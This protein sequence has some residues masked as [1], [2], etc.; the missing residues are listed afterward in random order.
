MITK[1]DALNRPIETGLWTNAIIATTHRTNATNLPEG[2]FE[3]P[4]T[5]GTYEI[6]TKTHYN[7]YIGLSSPLT[8]TLST[9]YINSTNFIMTYNAAPDLKSNGG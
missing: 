4:T 3:Y 7:D 9:T 8:S 5:T 1:Y 2:Q 6:L